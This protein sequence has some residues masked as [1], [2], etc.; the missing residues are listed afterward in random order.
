MSKPNLSI[1][2]EP[3]EGG[4]VVYLPLAPTTSGSTSP[5]KLVLRLLLKN[6]ESQAVKITGVSVSFPSSSQ[7]TVVMQGVN[8]DGS[9]DLA[10]G[11]QAFWSSGIVDL[12]PDPQVSNTVNNAMFLAQP[13]AAKGQVAVSCKGFTDPVTAAFDLAPHK[14]PTPAGYYRFPYA[15]GELRAD[16]YYTASAT[17]WANGGSA[18]GA[19]L[20]SRH[21][22]RGLRH[23]L[24]SVVGP[25]SW[26][27]ADEERGLPYLRQ[28]GTRHGRRRRGRS[29]GYDEQQRHHGRRP[30]A[31]SVPGSYAESGLGQSRLCAAWH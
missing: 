15:A 12:N 2:L 10:P 21:R 25:R 19:N 8:L 6:N 13:V 30:G 24:R 29:P 26:R 18:G 31:S 20:R 1:A 9:L 4:K 16:E 27:L 11:A 5:A 17:H 14:A 28:A 22:R 7:G 3:T 23:R